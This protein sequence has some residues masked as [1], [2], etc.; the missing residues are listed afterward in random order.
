MSPKTDLL[1]LSSILKKYIYDILYNYDDDDDDE[2]DVVVSKKHLSRPT[3]GRYD[4]KYHIAQKKIL[5]F[6]FSV[7]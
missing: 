5:K 1:I 2:D 7:A 6:S 4:V 3:T